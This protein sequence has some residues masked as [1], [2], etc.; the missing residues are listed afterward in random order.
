[1]R[2]EFHLE[3]PTMITLHNYPC[4]IFIFFKESLHGC[5]AVPNGGLQEIVRFYNEKEIT[6]CSTLKRDRKWSREFMKSKAP[7]DGKES[8]VFLSCIL[9][10]WLLPRSGNHTVAV[11]IYGLAYG[12]SSSAQ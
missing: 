10:P 7:E 12:L 4:S 5:I 1:M 2:D 3:W 6:A 11:L 8:D 9:Y